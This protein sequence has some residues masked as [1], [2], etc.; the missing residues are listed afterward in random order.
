MGI[1][2]TIERIKPKPEIEKTMDILRTLNEHEVP[3]DEASL[4]QK[5]ELYN[6]L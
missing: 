5:M 6:A 3:A 1:L 2:K 4:K